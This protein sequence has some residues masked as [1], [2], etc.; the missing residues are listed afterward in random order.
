MRPLSAG[1][2]AMGFVCVLLGGTFNRIAAKADPDLKKRFRLPWAEALRPPAGTPDR[3]KPFG[4]MQVRAQLS[5]IGYA[6]T[7]A[8]LGPVLWRVGIAAAIIGIIGILAS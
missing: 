5:A 2:L 4:D 3:L 6:V 1:I 7:M 8:K